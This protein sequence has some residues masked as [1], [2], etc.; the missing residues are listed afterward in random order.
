VNGADLE[1]IHEFTSLLVASTR[2]PRQRERLQRALGVSLSAVKKTWAAIFD[3]VSDVF[4]NVGD[5]VRDVTASGAITRGAQK[6]HRLLTYLH[7]HP[8]EIKP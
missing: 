5:D 1:R 4:P 8:E 7:N 2:S 6:R 3:K